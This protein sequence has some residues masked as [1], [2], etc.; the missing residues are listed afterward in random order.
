MG[1]GPPRA[2]LQFGVQPERKPGRIHGVNDV[3]NFRGFLGL[4][5]LQ[6]ADEMIARAGAVWQFRALLLEFLDIILAEIAQ[7]ELVGFEQHGGWKFLSDRDHLNV[8][9][10]ALG[11][12]GRGCDAGFDFV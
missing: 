3:E 12:R 10:I 6:M 2:C 8:G 5:G 4:V 7:A 9:P 11:A 1:A